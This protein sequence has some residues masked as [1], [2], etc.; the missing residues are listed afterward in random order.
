MKI[1]PATKGLIIS[2]IAVLFAFGV[3][4]LFLAK[5][6]YY[7]VDN[8]TGETYYF[9]INKGDEKIIGA[10]HPALSVRRYFEFSNYNAQCVYLREIRERT[11][12][13]SLVA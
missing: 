3:Y 13:F 10:G 7:L 6:N 12:P 8:P 9:R 5:K 11:A 4:F 2:V 1:S